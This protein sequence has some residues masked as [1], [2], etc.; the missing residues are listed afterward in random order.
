M[1]ERLRHFLLGGRRRVD[2]VDR[3]DQIALHAVPRRLAE[4]L[5]LVKFGQTFEQIE[6]LDEFEI[7]LFFVWRTLDFS[8]RFGKPLANVEIIGGVGRA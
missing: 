1:R 8:L 3:A 5:A 6:E 7:L 2:E 4:T